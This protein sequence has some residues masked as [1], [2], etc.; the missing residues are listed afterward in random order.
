MYSK[1]YTVS[2]LLEFYTRMRKS[3]ALYWGGVRLSIR[4]TDGVVAVA[5]LRNIWRDLIR[6]LWNVL[7][8]SLQLSLSR[9][10]VHFVCLRVCVCNLVCVCR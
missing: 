8:R 9:K 7:Y 3:N 2:V 4:Q 6:N 10:F 1:E 5:F